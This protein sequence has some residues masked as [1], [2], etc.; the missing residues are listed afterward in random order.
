MYEIYPRELSN[1]IF[2][3]ACAVKSWIFSSHN[4]RWCVYATCAT[5]VINEIKK[6]HINSLICLAQDNLCGGGG[7]SVGWVGGSFHLG[8]EFRSHLVLFC[9]LPPTSVV[10]PQ[11]WPRGKEHTAKDERELGLAFVVKR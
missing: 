1:F 5:V 7:R 8:S 2:G 11:R 6:C 4:I 9:P 10:G 3:E